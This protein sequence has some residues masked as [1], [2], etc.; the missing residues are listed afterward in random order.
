M[1]ERDLAE[2]FKP[3]DYLEGETPAEA[4][5]RI[6]QRDYCVVN[7]GYWI[8]RD[9]ADLIERQPARPAPSGGGHG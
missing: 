1:S 3:F 7:E 6:A 9:A 8:L 4:L 5:R 2:T